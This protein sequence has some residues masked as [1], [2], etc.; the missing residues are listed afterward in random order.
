M[1]FFCNLAVDTKEVAHGKGNL[2]KRLLREGL[3]TPEILEQLQKEWINVSS[4]S[5]YLDKNI[6]IC[7]YIWVNFTWFMRVMIHD[8]C[9]TYMRI[10]KLGDVHIILSKFYMSLLF[11]N[12]FKKLIFLTATYLHIWFESFFFYEKLLW[13]FFRMSVYCILY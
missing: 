7:T 4:V 6:E 12:N 13:S 10:K 5:L 3:L 2:T 1:I 11:P 9:S 8:L